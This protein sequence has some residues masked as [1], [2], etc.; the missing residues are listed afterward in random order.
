MSW[1]PH[2]Q[3]K[4]QK[5]G[6]GKQ[7]DVTSLLYEPV[8][9]PFDFSPEDVVHN[10]ALN[11]NGVIYILDATSGRYVAFSAFLTDFSL[12]ITP[13][14]DLTNSIFVADP[15]VARGQT[16]FSYSFTIDVPS[17]SSQEAWANLNKMQELY[18]FIGT[19]G[20]IHT[21]QEAFDVEATFKHYDRSREF[22]V[23]FSNLINNC[24]SSKPPFPNSDST[25]TAVAAI[26]KNGISGVIKNIEYKPSLE[27]GFFERRAEEERGG[28]T[29]AIGFFPKKFALNIELFMTNK[30][31]SLGKSWPFQ[32]EIK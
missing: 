11:T 1:K 7:N 10:H 22:V 16:A 2:H 27:D 12:N 6:E 15:F 14:I 4:T 17:R 9:H 20:N 25:D 30:H 28:D 23:F 26:W 5:R 8:D 31:S 13:K 29:G 32:M 21:V 3:N 19:L 24:S 18:R